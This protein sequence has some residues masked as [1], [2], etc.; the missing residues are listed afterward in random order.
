MKR[1]HWRK[2]SWAI[3]AWCVL[4]LIW[5]IAGGSSSA[6]N[7]INQSTGVLTRQQATNACD[8][9]A[10]IGVAIILFIG[11]IGFVFLS[12]IWLMTRPKGRDCPVC[13]VNVK[14]GQTT[15]GGCGHDFR[16]AAVPA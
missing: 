16:A 7:C 3:I 6:N 11:F 12:L 15:C 4:I 2:M 14:R 13:G 1:P 8:T 5:A 9:G 10:G